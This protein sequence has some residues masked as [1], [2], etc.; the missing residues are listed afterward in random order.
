MKHW[1]ALTG[2]GTFVSALLLFACC[3]LL[4]V[5]AAQDPLTPQQLVE[6]SNSASDISRLGA[7]RLQAV[8]VVRRSGKEANGMLI[9]E[10]D[11]DNVRQDLRFSDYHQLAVTKNDK[12]YI[13]RNMAVPLTL[14]G[15][16]NNFA[17]LWDAELG[18][19]GIPGAELTA[20]SPSTLHGRRRSALN[21]NWTRTMAAGNVSIPPHGC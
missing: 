4:P 15:R 20:V 2:R 9:V 21:S 14:L 10:R 16:L 8:V 3:T 7:Y 19:A 12:L 1:S 11:E 13:S 6:E 17:G 5:A 18:Q